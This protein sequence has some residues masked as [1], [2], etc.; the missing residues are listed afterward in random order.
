MRKPLL[1]LTVA[2]A[3]L[4]GCAAPPPNVVHAPAFHF[5]NRLGP[6]SQSISQVFD[7]GTTT[8]VLPKP[9]VAILGVQVQMQN[10]HIVPSNLSLDGAYYTFPGVYPS[11]RIDT[12]G[13]NYAIANLAKQ[14]VAT[15]NGTPS[16][17]PDR[18]SS[19]GS[20]SRQP[21]TPTINMKAGG[22]TQ[23]IESLYLAAPKKIDARSEG[24][25]LTLRLVDLIGIL[26][27]DWTVYPTSDVDA[28]RMVAVYLDQSIE[29]G[30]HSVCQEMSLSCQI[31]ATKK[32]IFLSKPA[33]SQPGTNQPKGASNK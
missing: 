17:T 26:P 2:T 15:S 18:V 3:A 14:E 5:W 11:I 33:P 28:H 22:N 4:A 32:T 19:T 31:N 12:L 20:E 6:A 23:T 24:G 8:Y 21:A 7:D 1:M 29:Q 16:V 30:M 10:G 25:I 27:D 9:G 13:H